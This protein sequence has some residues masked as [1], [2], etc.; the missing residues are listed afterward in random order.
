[1]LR[2]KQTRMSFPI[3]ENKALN[4]FDL[5]HCDIWGPYHVKSFCGAHY[6]LSIVDDASRGVW[7]Y[8][9]KEKSEASQL[10]RDF[11]TMA[12]T[13]FGAQVKIVRSDNGMEF[14]SNSMKK[15]YSE[16]GILHQTSCVDTPQQNGRVE[17]KH[18]YILNVAR[19][20]R[21]QANL[22]IEF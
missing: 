8:L 12:K 10:L 17:R 21:F 18:R 11:C 1:M 16:Q 5:I 7:I 6:F 19:A 4:C 15:V 22:P 13:Q 3:S 14:T 9:M 2:A 20:L